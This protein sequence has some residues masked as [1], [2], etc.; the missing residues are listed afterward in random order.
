MAVYPVFDL[1]FLISDGKVSPHSPSVDAFMPVKEME[2]FEV[3]IDGTVVDWSPMEQKGW[4]RRLMTGK[5]FSISL[6]GKR[7]TGDPGNDYVAGLALKTGN[8]CSTTAAVKFP[9]GALLVFDAVVDVSRH[10][11]GASTDVSGLDF[12]LLSDGK[13]TYFEASGDVT[14][15]TFTL[16]QK[17]GAAG[18]ADTDAIEIKFDG[19]VTGLLEENIFITSGSGSAAKDGLSGATDTWT[20]GIAAPQQGDIYIVIKGVDGYR[21]TSVPTKVTIFAS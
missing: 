18:S 14:Y 21:F 5:S 19:A 2:T 12:D 7:Q 20:L 13:P 17:N 3:A 16:T 4:V 9:D 1:E 15:R 6:A 11:G 10:F 8:A